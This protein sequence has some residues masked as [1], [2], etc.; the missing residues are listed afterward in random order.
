MEFWTAD[1]SA[2]LRE[3]RTAVRNRIEL[4]AQK[5]RDAL[6]LRY[7]LDPP[8]L[9]HYCDGCNAKLSIFHAL[10]CKRD[11]LVTVRH[12][13]LWDGVAELD[14]KEFTPITCV[15]TPSSLQVAP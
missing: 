10:D 13:E 8:D 14:G 2:C 12:N 4:G 1:H 15:T 5:W 3:G 6:F 11:G 7:G 9:P